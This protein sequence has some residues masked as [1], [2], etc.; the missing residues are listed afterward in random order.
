MTDHVRLKLFGEF[1]LE[2]PSG[3]LITINL[4]KA[5]ALLVY[6][7]LA[8]GQVTSRERL[9]SLLWGDS[10]QQRA[11][12][13]LRQA[14]FAL[15]K[16]FAQRDLSPLR[17]ESQSVRLVDGAIAA[18]AIEFEELL[19]DSSPAALARASEL[20]QGE[21]LSGFAVDAPDFEDWLTTTRDKFRHSAMRALAELLQIQ[22][23]AGELDQAIQTANRNL[24]IDP[25]WED[26]HRRLM[27][28]YVAKGMRTT[29]LSQ[30]RACRDILRRELGIKPDEETTQ[31]YREILDQGG[32]EAT[33]DRG[34]AESELASDSPAPLRER[35][36]QLSESYE[37]ISVGRKQELVSL[38]GLMDD[39]IR[40][41]G[42]LA[43]VLGEHGI[44]KSHLVQTFANLALGDDIQVLV[45]R[46]SEHDLPLG[47]WAEVL[48]EPLEREGLAVPDKTKEVLRT[49]FA[50]RRPGGGDTGKP[51]DDAVQSTRRFYLA[52]LEVLRCLA[53]DRPTALILEDIHW[54]DEESTRTLAFVARRLGLA[55]ILLVVTVDA[56]VWSRSRGLRR[57][58]GELEN[59]GLLSQ[60]Y[61]DALSRE[62]TIELAWQLQQE[63]GVKRDSKARL[64]RFW[65]LS[66]GNPRII[67]DAILTA[68]AHEDGKRKGEVPLPHSV[69]EEFAM[70]INRLGPEAQQLMSVAAVLGRRAN[71]EVV[72]AA[73]DLGAPQA[74]RAIEQLADERILTVEDDDVI[75]VHQRTALAT[76]A[77]IVAPRKRLLH[78]QVARAIEQ[79]H[80][81]NLEVYYQDLAKHY[82]AAGEVRKALD[83][84]LSAGRV[85]VNK[86]LP[87]KARRIYQHAIDTAR[88]MDHDVTARLVEIE[89][90]LELAA[91]AE[92]SDDGEGASA[93]LDAMEALAG[94]HGS[95]AHLAH[96]YAARSRLTYLDGDEGGAYELAGRALA[97]ADKAPECDLWLPVER[98]MAQVHLLAGA[99]G[100][101]INRMERRLERSARLDLSEDEAN[102]AAV[103]GLLHA[104]R[105]EFRIARQYCKQAIEG[106]EGLASEAS[107]IVCLQAHALVESWHGDSKAALNLF[108]RA[109]DTARACGDLLRLYVLIGHKGFALLSAERPDEAVAALKEALGMATRLNTSVFVPLFRAQLA[110]ASIGLVSDQ[111]A[112]RLAREALQ[113]A[114]DHNQS[115]AY[116]VG[117]RAIAQVLVRPTFRDLH[118]ADQAIR[119]AIASVSGLGL[120]FEI[121]RSLMVHAK[122]LRGRGNARRSSEIFAEASAMFERMDMERDFE[123][124]NT[125]AEALRPETSSG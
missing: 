56:E 80:A 93:C 91:L 43:L 42:H 54:I 15:S 101:V 89:A 72:R 99:R 117:Y 67:H 98:M 25:C 103:L 33:S 90:Q 36:S 81:G 30:F 27:R 52:V 14:L 92:K 55:P 22:E 34:F 18:D 118:S 96:L 58:A 84:E 87:T 107:M 2:D 13:S 77:H 62:D 12:Q 35:I 115:W 1:R 121:A 78:A 17:L 65:E 41:G 70:R 105:G 45:G 66:E 106:A 3:D 60:I 9:A 29:A 10:D 110:E 19:A 75:F 48:G 119:T 97:E 7:A 46:S 79:L 104:V 100:P 51:A 37:R 116:S 23:G 85:Q 53:A 102:T 63:L 64:Q 59:E 20:Y 4:R 61:L 49:G 111:D 68:A 32:G 86:G 122:I 120:Q 21:L 8:P 95:P 57:L 73:T 26:M 47:I 83:F 50:G 39:V 108:D 5:E 88:S 11:R 24:R 69:L 113:Q 40:R 38:Q 123:R 74:A 71:Y 6:V 124:A 112:L 44:G 109:I 114:T 76:Y 82:R 31:I 125:M 94:K 28:L 16:T